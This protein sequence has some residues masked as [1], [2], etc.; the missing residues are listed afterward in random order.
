MFIYLPVAERGVLFGIGHGGQFSGGNHH[1]LNLVQG[2]TLKKAGTIP[3]GQWVKV[4]ADVTVTGKKARIHTRIEKNEIFDWSGDPV[5]L[6]PEKRWTPPEKHQFALT[7][8]RS[9]I[10]FRNFQVQ[11]E[12]KA[13]K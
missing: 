13:T 8:L 5:D 4:N 7:V 2:E 10:A 6:T 1:S 9:R 12:T 3:N 11:G